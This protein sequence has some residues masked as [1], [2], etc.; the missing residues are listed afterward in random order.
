[1][2]SQPEIDRSQHSCSGSLPSSTKAAWCKEHPWGSRATAPEMQGPVP[3]GAQHLGGPFSRKRH[4]R[5]LGMCW[6]PHCNYGK[7]GRKTDFNQVATELK[8]KNSPP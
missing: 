4:C 8:G 5:W 6:E 1:M 3:R 7:L 2:T